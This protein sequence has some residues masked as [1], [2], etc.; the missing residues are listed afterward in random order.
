MLF[1]ILHITIKL[2]LKKGFFILYNGE[3]YLKK[4]NVSFNVFQIFI[5]SKIFKRFSYL[6][7]FLKKKNILGLNKNHFI[8]NFVDFKMVFSV[9]NDF[10]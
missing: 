5:A 2:N 3:D 7:K 4:K 9:I 1:L 6:N 10:F 8:N